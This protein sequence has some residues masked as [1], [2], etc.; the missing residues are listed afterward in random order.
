MQKTKDDISSDSGSEI[1]ELSGS[2]D[3]DSS[4]DNSA[5]ET[6]DQAQPE[7]TTVELIKKK[8][9]MKH[10]LETSFKVLAR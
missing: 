10:P 7:S 5:D 4:C 1:S 3:T 8:I 2:P 6:G 9:S